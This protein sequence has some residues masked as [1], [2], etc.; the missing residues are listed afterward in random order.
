MHLD[1]GLLEQFHHEME[2]K[3]DTI[4]ALVMIIEKQSRS[5][6]V[7]SIPKSSINLLDLDTLTALRNLNATVSIDDT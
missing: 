1:A 3:D 5:N 7:I 2:K 4:V 6:G